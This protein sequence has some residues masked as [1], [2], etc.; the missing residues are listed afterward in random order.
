MKRVIKSN[1]AILSGYYGDMR[2]LRKRVKTWYHKTYPT[3]D[4]YKYIPDNLTFEDVD[5][6]VNFGYDIYETLGVGDSL[7]RE[8]VFGELAN[9]TNRD[10][11]NIYKEWTRNDTLYR[12]WS[13]KQE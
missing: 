7:V 12:K 13:K 6:A 9:I 4:I 8:R 11:G 5:R 1:S 3:D 2:K 10:P